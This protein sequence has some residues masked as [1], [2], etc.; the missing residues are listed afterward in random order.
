M[1]RTF[2]ITKSYQLSYMFVLIQLINLLLYLVGLEES[3]KDT[4][5]SESSGMSRIT[6]IYLLHICTCLSDRANNSSN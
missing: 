1:L 4:K 2:G 6:I 5:I 3:F